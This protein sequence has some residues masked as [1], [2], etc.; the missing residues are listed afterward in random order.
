MNEI[1]GG[2]ATRLSLRLSEI[3]LL[4]QRRGWER[5]SCWRLVKLLCWSSAVVGIDTLESSHHHSRE[6]GMVLPIRGNTVIYHTEKDLYSAWIGNPN[7]P[8][9]I[10]TGS[11]AVQNT[12]P[13]CNCK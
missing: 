13:G 12:I 10:G 8:K 6:S 1:A 3:A 4:R 7:A 11:V 9:G 5:N 2:A